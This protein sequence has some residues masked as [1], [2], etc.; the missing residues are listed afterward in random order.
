MGRLL[1]AKAH[2]AGRQRFLDGDK[3]GDWGGKHSTTPSFLAKT[4]T[5]RIFSMVTWVSINILQ[6][7]NLSLA[8]KEV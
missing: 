3:Q 1:H 6:L 8:K 2:Q 5:E 4:G 7:S